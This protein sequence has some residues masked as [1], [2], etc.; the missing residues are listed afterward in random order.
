MEDIYR[1]CYRWY[2]IKARILNKQKQCKDAIKQLQDDM[3]HNGALETNK[4]LNFMVEPVKEAMEYAKQL[5]KELENGKDPRP[6]H[7]IPVSIKENYYLKLY[8]SKRQL[9]IGYYVSDG[10]VPPIP[11]VE[12]GL[13]EAKVALERFGH[14][15]YSTDTAGLPVAVQ[16]VALPYREE[17]ALREQV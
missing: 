1:V 5:D 14:T 8:E 13:L 16:C 4:T 9:R 11:G 7:G 17:M 2:R 3:D 6:L 12:R 15:Y 10:Y